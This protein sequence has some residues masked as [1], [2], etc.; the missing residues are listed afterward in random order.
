[1][2]AD[3]APP[4][5]SAPVADVAPEVMQLGGTRDDIADALGF[6]DIEDL[7]PDERPAPADEIAAKRD[8][9]ADKPK[10]DETP[11]DDVATVK[12]IEARG[13]ARRQREA[14]ARAEW[15]AKKTSE[16][17][18]AKAPAA[19]M[20]KADAPA[21]RASTPVESAVKDVLAMIGKLAG[22]DADA[23]AAAGGAAAPDTSERKAAMTAINK[24]LDEIGEGLKATKE[25]ETKLAEM[26]AQLKALESERVVRHHVSK[27]INAAADDLPLLTD[28]KSIRAFNKEHGTSYVDAIEMVGEA[29]ER[30]FERFKVAPDMGDLAKRIERKLSGKAP[31]TSVSDEKPTPKSKTVSRSDG[32]PPATRAAPNERSY[33]DAMEEFSQ[34]YG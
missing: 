13:K 26:Q 31:E 19:A 17:A 6:A 29:A 12:A 3:A 7:A 11:D 1:M 28:P 9:K 24:R 22:E 14:K 4:V 32:S 30:Y 8:A 5:E 21:A 18:S 33:E 34:K 2:S 20:P 15:Q 16:A 10:T 23:A 27:A 25:G